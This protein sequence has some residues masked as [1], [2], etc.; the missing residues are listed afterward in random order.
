M[1]WTVTRITSHGLLN[2]LNYFKIILHLILDFE[3]LCSA[4]DI[5]CT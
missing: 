2:V 1:M 4:N 3:S 5:M